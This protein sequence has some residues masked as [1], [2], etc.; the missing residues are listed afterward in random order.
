MHIVHT[1]DMCLVILYWG[2]QKEA[3]FIIDGFLFFFLISLNV[4]PRITVML[5]NS[6][7]FKIII[8]I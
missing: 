7:A 8:K 6:C 5:K 4:R 2:Q 3:V 1:I